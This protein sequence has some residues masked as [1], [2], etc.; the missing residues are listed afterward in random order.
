MSTLRKQKCLNQCFKAPF[1][2]LFRTLKTLFEA[3]VCVKSCVCFKYCVFH[4]FEKLK[5]VP[6]TFSDTLELL[7][8][9]LDTV[10]E[11]FNDFSKSYTR[12]E[13]PTITQVTTGTA[14]RA[15]GPIV[16]PRH[17]GDN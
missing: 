14:V 8:I 4:F 3:C 2:T 7:D 13:W 17:S 1:E 10:V 12:L 9:L 11:V 6:D 15:V 5:H 16:L